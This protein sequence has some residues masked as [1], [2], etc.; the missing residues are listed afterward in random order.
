MVYEIHTFGNGEILKGVFDSIAMCLNAKTGT[1]F[2]PLKRLGLLIGIF[3]AAIYSIYGDQIKAFTHW[4]IP[5][6]LIMNLLFVPT[7]SVWIHDPVTRFHQK[8]DH[9]PYGLA[10][11]AGYVSKIGNVVTEQVEKIFTL[12][13]DLR[14]QKS[15]SLFASN[16][17]QQAKTFHITNEDV[18]ENMRSFVAQCVVYD[19]MLGRK[20]TIEDLRHSD[21]IW[22][23]ISERASPVRSFVWRD[24]RGESGERGRPEIITCREG[25]AKFNALW[26]Q[27]L[28]RSA[29][30]YGRKIFG[31]NALISAKTE[32]LKY[33]PLSY[34]A[35]GDIAKSATEILKQQMMI[36]AVVDG[37][38]TQS[39]ALGNAPNF[40]ARRAYLQQRSTY[41]T[42]GAMA[43]EML[44]TMKAVLEAIAYACFLFV[45]PMA[46]LPFGWRFLL[47]WSQILLWLQ[48]WAPLYAILNYI[49]TMAAK[50]KTLASLSVSNEAG[51]TIASSVGI[52]NLNADIAAMSG[53]LAMSI[54]FL[55]I[56]LVKGVGSFVHLASHL[57][58]VSQSAAGSAASEVTS[59]NLSYGNVSESNMQIAN[60]GMF[61]QSRMASYKAGAFQ[62][63]DG[64]SDITTMADGSQVV[65]IG[66]SNLPISVNAADSIS[67]QQSQM[68]TK[69]HQRGLNLS[70]SSAQSLSSATR[71]AV[72]LSDSL[73]RMEGVGDAV[74]HGVST[75]QSTAIHKG[76]NLVKDFAQQNQIG[77]DKAAKLLGSTG[78]GF[79]KGSGIFSGSLGADGSLSAH[80]QELYTKAQKYAEDHNFQQAM[81]EAAQASQTLSHNLSD[82]SSKRLADEVSGSYERGEQQRFEASKSFS[83]SESY[84]TQAMLTQSN[85]ATINRNAN[86]EFM[87]WIANQPADNAPGKL[88]HHGASYI[89]S[90]KPDE[91]VSYAQRFM[92]EKG[93]RAVSHINPGD[94]KQDY[95]SD[96]RH[97][98]V[99]V[100]KDNLEQVRSRAGEF[101]SIQS[102]GASMREQV[103][104]QQNKHRQNIQQESQSVV[105]FGNE[106]K[107]EV[108][109]QQNKGVTR[110]LR[111]KSVKEIKDTAAWK[112]IMGESQQK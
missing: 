7:T 40:A 86:Q 10:A 27:E 57:G 100:S 47:N 46:L 3:W 4:I 41:E 110:R 88:G 107:T 90:N 16:I 109:K 13:D 68:A 62:F 76:A 104:E 106:S 5:M 96:Q 77:T 18:A 102:K 75:E 53:Y 93:M 79:G 63:Q 64:R 69:A 31:K 105:E 2:E 15:G 44:P 99:E 32:I 67:S 30:V 38:E 17:I 6:A 51:V 61:S 29:T 58:N 70:Q 28:D 11:F 66:T 85:A 60:T 34:S 111:E 54:P 59:G 45:I 65:N 78:V 50:S 8:V 52:A 92:Q 89:I 87:D 101:T 1:L 35:L 74:S 112:S 91:T 108:S 98:K 73:A 84:N 14:Y 21:D 82:E 56:A 48:M 9:I 25:V 33:L 55:C 20:Y 22:H 95:E 39:T 26:G 19:A 36:Y 49:M 42:L 23:L 83:E 94:L 97:Q 81:R 37:I 12:P 103:S 43:G 80:D 72:S 71:S 24:L